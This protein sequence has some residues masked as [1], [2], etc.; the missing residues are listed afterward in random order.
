MPRPIPPYRRDLY[1]PKIS[2]TRDLNLPMNLF[3]YRQFMLCRLY[4][5]IRRRYLRRK[6]NRWR[7]L[8]NNVFNFSSGADDFVFPDGQQLCLN[9]C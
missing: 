5:F 8:E 7:N 2:L 9:R 3:C 6:F 4:P 1:L